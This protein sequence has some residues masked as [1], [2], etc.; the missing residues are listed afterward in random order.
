MPK[1]AIDILTFR[2]RIYFFLISNSY[3]VDFLVYTL[4]AAC[5]SIHITL[6]MDIARTK[7]I[8]KDVLMMVVIVVDLMLIQHIVLNVYAI[9]KYQ[10]IIE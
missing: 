5:M 2:I 8:M 9:N 4:Q 1:P 6:V 10:Y 7:Q 3:D